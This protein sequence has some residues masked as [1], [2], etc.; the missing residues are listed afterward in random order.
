MK[1]LSQ[2]DSSLF[3]R[4]GEGEEEEKNLNNF[5]LS[6]NWICLAPMKVF[7]AI[8]I[9]VKLI[10][11]F[12]HIKDLVGNCWYTRTSVQFHTIRP[13]KLSLASKL[14]LTLGYHGLDI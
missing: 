3:Q 12:S 9:F 8:I 13:S 2:L 11:S 4:I 6:V 5:Q 14:L 1:N 7:S 10:V